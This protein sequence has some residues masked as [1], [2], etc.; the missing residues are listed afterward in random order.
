MVCKLYH[1]KTFR[2]KGKSGEIRILSKDIGTCDRS[3]QISV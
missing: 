3:K 2:E 1:N